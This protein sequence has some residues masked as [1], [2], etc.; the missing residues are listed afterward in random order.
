MHP[1]WGVTEHDILRA[2]ELEATCRLRHDTGFDPLSQP[3]FWEHLVARQ[4]GGDITAHKALHDV[5]VTIWDCICRA[6]VKYST[7]F[8]MTYR[9]IRG[10]DWSRPSFKWALPRGNSGK[11]GVDAIVLVGRED[12][13]WFF[14]VVPASEVSASCASITASAPSVRREGSWSRLDRW[15]V[16]WDVLLPTFARICHN[17]YDQKHRQKNASQTRRTKKGNGE[18]FDAATQ[19]DTRR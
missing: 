10:K 4:L 16:P 15:Q 14:W 1:E 3:L 8:W 7:A 5:E 11:A 6:E 2:V 18:L 13:R 19:G 12:D 9:P 17:R